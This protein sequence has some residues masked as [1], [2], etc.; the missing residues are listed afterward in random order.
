[1]ATSREPLVLLA[2]VAVVCI[3]LGI[4]PLADRLTWFLENAPVLIAA[5]VLVLTAA[6]FPLS[7]LLYRLLALHALVLMIGGHWTYA[8]VPAGNW[9]RDAFG[10]ARNPYD[11]LGHLMQG[12]VPVL[13]VRELLL[14]RDEVLARGKLATV[15]LLFIVLGISAAYELIEWQAAVWTGEAADAFLGSQGDVWDSQWDMACALIGA[16][17]ALSTLSRIHDR[18]MSAL[19]RPSGA[20]TPAA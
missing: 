13:L 5:P 14:R 11:R 8:E 1:M 10:L 9:L 20:A 17:V 16:I 6:R 15:A 4:A 12:F 18:Q 3:A 7:P 2:I 19:V